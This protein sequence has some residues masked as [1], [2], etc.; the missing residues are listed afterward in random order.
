MMT[1]ID[2]H[3]HLY[4]EEFD[5]DRELVFIRA[6]QAGVLRMFL[7]NIDDTTIARLLE[8]CRTHDGCYPLM[9]LHPTSVDAGWRDRLE[10]VREAF[11]SGTTYYGVGEVGLDFYWD[12]TYQR[13]QMEVF[14]IQLK[15]AIEKDLP[16]I[17][18]CRDAYDALLEVMKPYQHT[19]LRG[20]FHSFTAGADVAAR[21]LRY[22]HFMLGINGVVTFKNSTL[23]DVLKSVP[24]SRIVLETDSPYL[25]PVPYRGKR[26]ESANLLEIARKAA[27]IYELPLA[28][29]ARETT[30]NAL[31]VFKN[32]V[33]SF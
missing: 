28:Q 18:H 10:R 22:P 16:L 20:I 29:I 3:T 8:T 2:T 7:P 6:G 32:A 17:I 24:L 5:A 1:L 25:A 30:E 21:L 13:E 33:G 26:N 4:T 12:R 15:W 9:G 27:E 19:G 31:K 11:E 14:E 23:S